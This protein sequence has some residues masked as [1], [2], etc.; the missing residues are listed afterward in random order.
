MLHMHSVDKSYDG[1][2][3]NPSK[4]FRSGLCTYME[5]KGE[6]KRIQNQDLKPESELWI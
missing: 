1:C 2:V 3:Q 5:K 4:K 6:N